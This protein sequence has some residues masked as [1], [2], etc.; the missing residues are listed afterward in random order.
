MNKLRKT[1]LLLSLQEQCRTDR[2]TDWLHLHRRDREWFLTQPSQSR[3]QL[4]QHWLQA[5]SSQTHLP[6][7]PSPFFIS[8]VGMLLGVGLMSG[9][10]EFQPHQRINIWWWLLLGVWLPALWWMLGLWL[11]RTAENSIWA[12][13]L[14]R[15]LPSHAPSNINTPLLRLTAQSMSQQLSLG[16]AFGMAGTFFL[17]LLLSDLAFGWSSTLDVT[18]EAVHRVVQV[19]GIPWNTLWPNAVPSLELVEQTRFF[20]GEN[21]PSAN[22]ET[23]AQWW[24][25]LLMNLLCY[26]LAPRIVSFAWTELKLHRAQERL[27]TQDACLDGWWQRLHFEQVRQH[28]APA[29]SN[30]PPPSIEVADSPENAANDEPNTA[31]PQLDAIAI[32][33]HWQPD[34]LDSQVAELPPSVRSL[35]RLTSN[36][37]TQRAESGHAFLLLCKGWEPPTGSIADLCQQMHEQ[38]VRLYI[39]PAPLPGMKAGRA[40]QL[41]ESWQ[42]FVPQLPPSCHLLDV[43]SHA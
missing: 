36:Q 13:N 28:A 38:Q 26:V 9:L 1:F 30:K 24:R 19:L 17:Y 33:G 23:A 4:A 25:F 8:L 15:R 7:L 5:F 29:P 18:S 3:W 6:L 39:W 43:Q 21:S 16:F 27:F 40:E 31:W 34:V 11:G 2:K 20:R 22:A 14:T 41:R 42:L 35:P 12:K 37:L 32:A 10:L